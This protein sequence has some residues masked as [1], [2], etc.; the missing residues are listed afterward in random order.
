MV[1]GTAI[2]KVMPGQ[3]KPVYCSLKGKEG[4][5]DLYHVFGEYDFFLII[6]AE[7]LAKLNGLMEDI[8][9]DHRVIKA[10]TYW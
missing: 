3:E 7:S 2:V 5:L 6:Q 10:R 1:I 4:L 8:Q 9:K